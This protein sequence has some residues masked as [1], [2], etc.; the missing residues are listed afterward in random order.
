MKHEHKLGNLSKLKNG[1]ILLLLFSIITS[2]T[3]NDRTEKNLSSKEIEF[4]KNTCKLDKDE[5][6]LL[7]ET[8]AG[9]S[10]YKQGGNFIT[11]KRVVSYWIEDE[12]KTVETAYYYEIDSIK[13]VDKSTAVTLASYLFIYKSDGLNFELYIDADS[14]R[15]NSFYN[16][17][18]EIWNDKKTRE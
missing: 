3:L 16:K 14:S 11:N 2:C 9:F 15:L 8:N 1:L 7:F 4:I 17:T 6:I 13:L 10:G 12:E 5:T 18:I